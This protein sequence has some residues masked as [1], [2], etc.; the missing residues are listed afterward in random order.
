MLLPTSS[1]RPRLSPPSTTGQNFQWG[2]Q[3]KE[4]LQKTCRIASSQCEEVP[5]LA[6]IYIWQ[7][8]C[9]RFRSRP[10]LYLPAIFVLPNLAKR[11]TQ[12]SNHVL[13]HTKSD[14]FQA[15]STK[16]CVHCCLLPMY[17][18]WDNQAPPLGSRLQNRLIISKKIK[19]NVMCDWL[20]TATATAISPRL[21]TE[22][23]LASGSQ[24]RN[25]LSKSS[26]PSGL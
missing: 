14:D 13:F 23:S 16:S 7:S 9:F 17:W 18:L 22:K 26:T 5:T 6:T 8:N 3:I 2:A 10:I 12:T 19:K 4:H 1:W 11:S 25:C 21:C 24:H 15:T 20:S